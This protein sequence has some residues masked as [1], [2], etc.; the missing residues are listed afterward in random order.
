MGLFDEIFINPDIINFYSFKC[1][2][3][4]S[5]LTNYKFQSKCLDSSMNDY[6]LNYN[7]NR[8]P[9]LFKL[10]GPSDKKYWHNYT[11]EEIK[12]WNNF[13]GKFFPKRKKGD[14]HWT[15]E[16]F[17]PKNRKNR[18]MGQLPHQWMYI[19]V[20]CSCD[21]FCEFKLK[22]TDGILKKVESVK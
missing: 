5:F 17:W 9:K 8:D 22:F 13:S 15:T 16:A 7:N 19:Y 14:G 3:C 2:K 10:D 21:N 11:N 20:V 1:F 4:N 6:Y 12:E 18:D